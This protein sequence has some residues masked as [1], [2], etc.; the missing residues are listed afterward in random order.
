MHLCPSGLSLPN[1]APRLNP[2]LTC[3]AFAA[4]LKAA[5]GCTFTSTDHCPSR[6][7]CPSFLLYAQ[8]L[9]GRDGNQQFAAQ[10]A[11]AVAHDG[12]GSFG[13]GGDGSVLRLA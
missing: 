9:E 3:L 2:V 1:L 5:V 7:Q 13:S 11:C 8:C 4:A 6:C 10:A 12:F